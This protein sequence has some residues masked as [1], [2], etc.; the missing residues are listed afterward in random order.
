MARR[1]GPQKG[2]LWIKGPSWLCRWW[3]DVRDAE[4]NTIRVQFS[5]VVCPARTPEGKTVTKHEAQRIAY[6]TVL[7]KLDLATQ[8]PKSL[9]TVERF[10]ADSFTPDWVWGCKPSGKRHYKTQL[11][12]VTA[13]LGKKP[14]RSVTTEDVQRAAREMIAAGKSVQTVTHFRNTVG[15]IFTHAKAI[16]HFTGDNP[17]AGVRLPPMR[18]RAKRTLTVDQARAVLFGLKSPVYEIVFLSMLASLNVAEL[19]ALRW[20][21]VNLTAAFQISDGEALAPYCVAVRENNYRGEFSSTKTNSRNRTVPLSETAVKILA[22][23]REASFFPGEDDLVFVNGK[24]G[25]LNENNM[26]RRVLKPL[27]EKIGLPFKLSWHVFRYTFASLAEQVEMALSDKRASMGHS[28][29]A[30]SL[31]YTVSDL[32]RRRKSIEKIGA[33]LVGG[34]TRC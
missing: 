27:G 6:S 8:A 16:G 25:G 3:E 7:A 34:A 29:V 28:T 4:G 5:K 13:A 15:S 20:R 12:H 33:Y 17:A 32:E 26:R 31:D 24:G 9:A 10:I 2:Q 18:R 19:L 23:F 30:M 22:E 14:L 1:R 11:K 21:R